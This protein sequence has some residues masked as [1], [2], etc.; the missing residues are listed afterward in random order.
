MD[1]DQAALAALRRE[2]KLLR[3]ENAYLREQ[4]VLANQPRGAPLA[5]TGPAAIAAGI[6]LPASRL[7]SSHGAPPGTPGS[8]G[9]PALPGAGGVPAAPAA[10]G[11][12]IGSRPASGSGGG[13]GAG[14]QPSPEDLMRRLL[15]T[16]RML[17]AYSRENDRL[18]GENG[19]LRTGKTMVA[20]DYKGG[21]VGGCSQMLVNRGSQ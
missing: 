15:E 17:V 5:V 9:A 12:G 21:W 16:Q 14:C 2:I 19:R 1:P 11:A 8:S 20:N 7:P 13:A 4:L 6:S 10:G 3:S 18:A